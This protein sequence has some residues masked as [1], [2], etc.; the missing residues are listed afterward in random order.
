M[1]V[2]WQMVT[3]LPLSLQLLTAFAVPKGVGVVLSDRKPDNVNHKKQLFRVT[4][5]DSGVSFITSEQTC[6]RFN[7]QSSSFN[8]FVFHL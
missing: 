5:I 7:L 3:F 8:I 4:L 2:P 1:P 6:G